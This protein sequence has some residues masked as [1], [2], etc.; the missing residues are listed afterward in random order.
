MKEP[1]KE[2]LDAF[3]EN[4]LDEMFRRVG[5]DGMD[6]KFMEQD[7]WYLLR[8]WSQDEDKAFVTWMADEYAKLFNAPK[9]KGR[10]IAN[11][12]NFQCG[13]KVK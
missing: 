1:K 5:F 2:E 10:Q 13:W 7:Q 11:S 12:F 3:Y 9:Y 6:S 8:E 4:S